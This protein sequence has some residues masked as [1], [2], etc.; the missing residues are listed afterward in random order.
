MLIIAL[1]GAFVLYVVLYFFYEA[2]GPNVTP[3][4]F[5]VAMRD[6]IFAT[7]DTLALSILKWGLILFAF[8]IVGD[9][10]LAFLKKSRKD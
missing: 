5:L 7:P 2:A 3:P 9:G 1:I 4:S 8:Y 10:I 6:M